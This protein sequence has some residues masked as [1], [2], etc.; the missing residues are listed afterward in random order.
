MTTGTDVDKSELRALV[1]DV[2]DVEPEAVTDEAHFIQ[3]LGV[4]SLIALELAVTLERRYEIKI[5][6]DEIVGVKR[7]PDVAALLLAKVGR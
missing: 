7:L 3:D 1:A 5:S 4:D 2:L 6:E